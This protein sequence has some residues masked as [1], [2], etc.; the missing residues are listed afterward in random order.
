MWG[1]KA[2]LLFFVFLA[3]A[4]CMASILWNVGIYV[5]QL[6]A[7]EEYRWSW[8]FLNLVWVGVVACEAASS[9]LR[10]GKPGKLD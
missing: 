3:A 4:S 10:I 2:R 7:L 9:L 5:P 8:M 6:S 1:M